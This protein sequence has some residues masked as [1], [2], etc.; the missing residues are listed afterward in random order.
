M[1]KIYI[2]INEKLFMLT[3]KYIIFN[4]WD[5]RK[6]SCIYRTKFESSEY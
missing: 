2:G 6:M 5:K 4:L 3:T 1:N